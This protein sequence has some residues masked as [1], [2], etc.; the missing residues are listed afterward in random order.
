[1]RFAV[2]AIDSSLQV[3][4]ALLAAWRAPGGTT[5]QADCPGQPGSFRST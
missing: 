3:E 4:V 2:R 5:I 1:L